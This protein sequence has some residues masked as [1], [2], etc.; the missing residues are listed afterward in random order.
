MEIKKHQVKI[1]IALSFLVCIKSRP[2]SAS[3]EVAI[4]E[5]PQYQKLKPKDFCVLD[6]PQ[7]ENDLK[8]G[9][10]LKLEWQFR[11]PMNL[12]ETKVSISNEEHMIINGTR[13]AT[14]LE[15]HNNWRAEWK[16]TEKNSYFIC[17]YT[18]TVHRAEYSDEI[19]AQVKINLLGVHVILKSA[20]FHIRVQ[21]E[22]PTSTVQSTE[23]N[24]PVQPENPS[25]LLT[26]TTTTL[27]LTSTTSAHPKPTIVNVPSGP[28]NRAV[29]AI[30]IVSAIVLAGLIL[31]KQIRRVI[32]KSCNWHPE[33][34]RTVTYD[35]STQAIRIGTTDP[36]EPLDQQLTPVN[37]SVLPATEDR[38]ASEGVNE[39]VKNEP[40]ERLQR[41]L[42]SSSTAITNQVIYDASTQAIRI[43]TTDPIEPLDQQL[44]PVNQSVL[45]PTDQTRI[46]T[47]DPNEP[48]SQ[49][50]T[51]CATE[52]ID[53]PVQG[54][55]HANSTKLLHLFVFTL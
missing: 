10:N 43:G 48:F 53:Q 40:T 45:P 30:V 38:L 19:V 29:I 8:V 51:S 35:A 1:Y 23:V 18:V 33:S 39:I 14:I 44:T 13:V 6:A 21:P 37:Q 49:Q 5:C 4:R 24:T 47:R 31:R 32:C 11:S 22:S 27:P 42:R 2:M 52:G 41:Q 12:S 25:E 54:R 46:L 55:T 36:I 34:Q 7:Y 26:S 50:V 15:N 9:D 20:F 3:T 28:S 16:C 17:N